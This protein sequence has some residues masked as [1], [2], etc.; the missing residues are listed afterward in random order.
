MS[1]VPREDDP[2]SG[3]RAEA[4]VLSAIAARPDLMSAIREDADVDT[5]R[6]V[7]VFMTGDGQVDRF[8]VK[9]DL[10][11]LN[12]M[13]YGDGIST[14]LGGIVPEM[15]ARQ[16][17]PLGL[18]PE[19]LGQ[20]GFTFTQEGAKEVI[21]HYAWP[22]RAGEP[23]GGYMPTDSWVFRAP[24]T[25]TDAAAVVEHHLPGALAGRGAVTTGTPW[26]L[27]SSR[28]EVVDSGYSPS[29]RLLPLIVISR[30]APGAQVHYY[31]GMSVPGRAGE[32]APAQ[33]VLGWLA[34]EQSDD[35]G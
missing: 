13:A 20:M 34:P 19:Q 25:Y 33:V 30:G 4:M 12:D 10:I 32:S 22:R 28:G 16:W 18:Q 17:E 3:S 35:P 14:G 23:L 27:L 26:L 11:P 2:R 15:L 9:N 21:V 7:I 5:A 8:I 6:H 29:Q 24:F 31:M 1:P